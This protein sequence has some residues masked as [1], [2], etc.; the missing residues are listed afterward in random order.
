M[1]GGS[2]RGHDSV[3]NGSRNEA[4]GGATRPA[5]KEPSSVSRDDPREATGGATI[6]GGEPEEATDGAT[7]GAGYPEKATDGATIG[8]GDQ[9]SPSGGGAQAGGRD[10]NNNTGTWYPEMGRETAADRVKGWRTDNAHANND[11]FAVVYEG[12][13]ECAL[14]CTIREEE[15]STPTVII[16]RDTCVEGR[17][18]CT[19]T[20]AG[21]VAQ[22]KPCRVF[23]ELFLRG[24]TDPDWHYIIRG[25]VFGFSVINPSCEAS[26][27]TKHRRVADPGDRET[28][29]D[30]LLAEIDRGCI[31]VVDAP[32]KCVHDIFCIPKEGGGTRSIVDCS[33]PEGSS[34]NN[35]TNEV[36]VKFSYNSVDDVA[37]AMTQGDFLAT[38]DIKDAYRAICIHPRDRGRQ[39]LHW[40]FPPEKGD[41]CTYME[42][43]RLCMGLSSSPYVFSKVSDF[44]VRCA[45]REGVHRVVNYLDDFCIISGSYG[46][47]RRDQQVM[48]AVL[49]RLGFNVSFA[50]VI[51]P[52]TS[53]RFLGINI[54]TERLEMSLPEDKL[55]KLK[56]ILE[57]FRG[58]RKATRRELERL[59][60]LLAHC[61][62]VIKGGRTFCRRIYDAMNSVKEPHYKVKLGPGF[63]EDI[64]WW[65]DF[66]ARFNGKARI[67]GRFAAHVATYSDASDWGYGAAHDNDWIAGAFDPR[68]D[69]PLGGALGHHH[70]PPDPVCAKAHINVREMWAAYSAALRWGH[71]WTNCAVVVVTDSTT[72]R[73]ALNTGRSRSSE[74][75]YFIRRLFWLACENNFEFS[76]VY[77]CSADNT[78]CDALSRLDDPA[79][80]ARLSRADSDARMCCNNIFK[81]ESL[82]GYR[83]GSAGERKGDVPEPLLR[84]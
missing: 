13:K 37:E 54:D 20:I 55:T 8:G 69:A 6:G 50:K 58:R 15:G 53:V 26:Y 33:K 73:A 80:L 56:G 82:L 74:I 84:P 35:F 46:E 29:T 19:H 1:S 23:C 57:E 36:S 28:I 45:V 41:G 68:D 44:V 42:D 12:S 21:A 77:I 22:L 40:D 11:N 79:S 81:R 14:R 62:K 27:D 70:K 32:P 71:L 43:N 39:G 60:G 7:I 30:K 51:S 38:T 25:V 49:R 64:A 16:I 24:D 75:M 18:D 72:V 65:A 78:I 17:C 31:S 63:R 59:G 9:H 76:S 61:S 34:V 10:N 83:C 66:A 67:L 3:R 2:A 52:S 4:T 48:I 5:A 47:G